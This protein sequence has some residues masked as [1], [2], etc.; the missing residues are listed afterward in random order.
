MNK[1]LIFEKKNLRSLTKT[2]RQ[3]ANGL[4]ER[5]FIIKIRIDFGNH[6]IH[7]SNEKFGLRN[8]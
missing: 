5:L 1:I 2:D 3:K 8:P 6:F 7:V 4:M